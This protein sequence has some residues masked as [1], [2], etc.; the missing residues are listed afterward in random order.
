MGQVL[1]R[2]RVIWKMSLQSI[3][4]RMYHQEVTNKYSPS[5]SDVTA[6]KSNDKD[7]ENLRLGARKLLFGLFCST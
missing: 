5:V 2:C 4:N 1:E 6:G 7:L 3:I